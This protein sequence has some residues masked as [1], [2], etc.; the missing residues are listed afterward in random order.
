MDFEAIKKEWDELVDK[1][2][3]SNWETEMLKD[4]Q[5]FCQEKVKTLPKG[6]TLND[7]GRELLKLE[8]MNRVFEK[9][10]KPEFTED[11]MVDFAMFCLESHGKGDGRRS[12]IKNMIDSWK[13]ESKL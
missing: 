5:K 9:K 4:W 3:S 6:E 11:Q 13:Q 8:W 1:T 7:R 10:Q 2:K 12:Y